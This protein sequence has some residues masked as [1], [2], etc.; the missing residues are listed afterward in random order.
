M[1]EN[2]DDL[3]P[4]TMTCRLCGERWGESHDFPGICPVYNRDGT[5]RGDNTNGW[6]PP[7]QGGPKPERP[8]VFYTVTSRKRLSGQLDALKLCRQMVGEG[9]EVEVVERRT[10]VPPPH[11]IVKTIFLS[12]DF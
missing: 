3:N 2:F 12:G 11:T 5:R 10:P 9:W 7:F 4:H 6:I 1:S 8:P